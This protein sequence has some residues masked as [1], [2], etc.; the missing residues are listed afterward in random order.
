V[1]LHALL[2]GLSRARLV[3]EWR[4]GVKEK[5]FFSAQRNWAKAVDQ[6][7]TIVGR[8][9]ARPLHPLTILFLREPGLEG[10]D[11]FFHHLVDPSPDG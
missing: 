7:F 2:L 10:V 6:V 3:P 1:L 4:I 9:L 11:K 5:G 8:G